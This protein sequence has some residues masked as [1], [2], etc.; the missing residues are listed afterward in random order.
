MTSLGIDRIFVEWEGSHV[1]FL[2]QRHRFCNPSGVKY[3]RSFIVISL[4]GNKK[5]S[6]AKKGVVI[7]I[8]PPTFE[9]VCNGFHQ[10]LLKLMLRLFSS[11]YFQA[12]GRP[13]SA[14]SLP[15]PKRCFLASLNLHAVFGNT[16]LLNMLVMKE[17]SAFILHPR[18]F[19]PV[20]DVPATPS[21]SGHWQK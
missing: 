21:S 16:I 13:L 8:I 9:K 1:H 12:R 19:F 6:Y 7:L 5:N 15:C 18:D 14:A 17:W 4:D 2:W 11:F 3:F 20:Q 10:L